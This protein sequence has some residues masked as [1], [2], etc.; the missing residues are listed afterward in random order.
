MFELLKAYKDEN[1][2]VTPRGREVFRSQAIG[3]WIGEQR[4]SYSRQ[5]KGL[6]G[7][8]NL[9]EERV[10][11]LNEIGFVWKVESYIKSDKAGPVTPGDMAVRDTTNSTLKSRG[12]PGGRA[13]S[14]DAESHFSA[15]TNDREE[16]DF[17]SDTIA[18]EDTSGASTA[19]AVTGSPAGA[20]SESRPPTAATTDDDTAGSHSKDTRPTPRKRQPADLGR[21]KGRWDTMLDVLKA[22]R[23]EKKHMFPKSREIFQS[24]PIGRWVHEQR[25][26]LSKKSGGLKA[27]VNLSEERIR[28]LNE[29][30]FPWKNEKLQRLHERLNE[31]GFSW[32]ANPSISEAAQAPAGSNK[33]T[34]TTSGEPDATENTYRRPRGNILQERWDGFFELLKAYN[35]ENNNFHPAQRVRFQER[36]LGRWVCSFLYVL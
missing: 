35:E 18:S 7:N 1:D 25:G 29:I 34:A 32:E 27:K 13:D 31:I 6:K 3:T 16:K 15:R 19:V 11:R 33:D 10:A 26:A 8:I 9:T 36:P 22:Y 5:Q 4:Y 28:R 30:G 21:G 17:S 23:D 12:N 20:E 24:Y 14:A 2:H